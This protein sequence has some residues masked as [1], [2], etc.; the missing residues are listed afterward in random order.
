MDYIERTV[1]PTV[2]GDFPL[3]SPFYTA[4][5][6]MEGTT[7][8]PQVHTITKGKSYIVD[9]A[10]LTIDRCTEIV[11]L[12]IKNRSVGK[13][14]FTQMIYI[15]MCIDTMMRFSRRPEESPFFQGLYK[16]DKK[17]FL[18]YEKDTKREPS[19]T[20]VNCGIYLP[21]RFMQI[22]HQRPQVGGEI[23]SMMKVLRLFRLTQRKPKGEKCIQL[24]AV[25]KRYIGN[26]QTIFDHLEGRVYLGI[27]FEP[28]TPKTVRLEEA[29]PQSE[30]DKRYSLN[31]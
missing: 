26:F 16:A 22:D 31:E 11:E 9:D 30:L 15:S 29:D 1:G 14:N 5:E 17:K 27:G 7:I 28:V 21:R 19:I 3:A 4:L 8:I 18:Y 6:K 20:C 13:V 2:R 23:E 24:Y 12:L 10:R 25:Y